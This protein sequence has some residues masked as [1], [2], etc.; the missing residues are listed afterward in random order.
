MARAFG[1]GAAV[2]LVDG[3]GDSMTAAVVGTEVVA[4]MGGDVLVHPEK[5]IIRNS[6]PKTAIV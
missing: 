1:Y 6:T 2:G 3:V 5:R 4:W